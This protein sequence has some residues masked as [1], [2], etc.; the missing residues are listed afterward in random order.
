MGGVV[1]LMYWAD[2]NGTEEPTKFET[3]AKK[4]YGTYL[5]VYITNSDYGIKTHG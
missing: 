2:T 3:W 1:H 5:G 4:L